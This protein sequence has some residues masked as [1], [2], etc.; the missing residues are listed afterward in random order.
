MDQKGRPSPPLPILT[1]AHNIITVFRRG[2][3]VA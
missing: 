2:D 3:R 1:A